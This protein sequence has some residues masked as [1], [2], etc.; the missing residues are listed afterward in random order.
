MKLMLEGSAC[1]EDEELRRLPPSLTGRLKT[2]GAVPTAMD[3][4]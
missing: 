3:P 1:E 4:R 2:L